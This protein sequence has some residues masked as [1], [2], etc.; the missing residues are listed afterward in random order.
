MQVR[1][2][3]ESL[4]FK[5]IFEETEDVLHIATAAKIDEDIFGTFAAR[6]I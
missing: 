4:K 6:T 2:R 1:T 3:M 5:E